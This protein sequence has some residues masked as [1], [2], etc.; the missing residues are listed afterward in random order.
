MHDDDEHGYNML[1]CATYMLPLC[2]GH[3]CRRCIAA[4]TQLPSCRC[5]T[6][7]MHCTSMQRELRTCS[8]E[9]MIA[10]LE[11]SPHEKD[12]VCRTW[13]P[14]WMDAF[15]GTAASDNHSRVSEHEGVQKHHGFAQQDD[16]RVATTLVRC[17]LT[18]TTSAVRSTERAK[19]RHW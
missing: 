4:C 14:G 19:G 15:P 8:P 5:S 10:A 17:V 2:S 9:S 12:A 16:S 6:A 1:P 11:V 18:A 13:Q 7:A 3:T